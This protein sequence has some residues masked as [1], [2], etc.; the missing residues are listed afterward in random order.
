MRIQH[1]PSH[2]SKTN[3]TAATQHTVRVP[4]LALAVGEDK[5]TVSAALNG[6]G[7]V[8]PGTRKAVLRAA[9][10]LGFAGKPQTARSTTGGSNLIGL[11]SLD[12][13]LGVGT[14][15]IKTI[16]RLLTDNGYDVPVYSYGSTGAAANQAGLLRA[17]CRQQPQ[18]IVCANVGLHPD[19]LRELQTYEDKG[20]VVVCYDHPVEIA[21]DNV[22]FDREANTYQAARHLLEL[23][24]RDIALYVHGPQPPGPTRLGGFRRACA[25]FGVTVRPDWLF[26]GGLYET[27]GAQ[28]A[29]RFMELKQRPTA[30]CIVNDLA[31]V[32]FVNELRRMGLRVPA[33]VS[34]VGHD[35]LPM[36][37]YCALPLTTVSHPAGKIAR[38]VV[39]LL[40]S[41]LE[42]RYDGPPRRVVVQGELIVRASTAAPR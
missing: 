5:A 11:F 3:T 7:E 40:C 2:R 20:G 21:C 10:Q 27:G 6:T 18:A 35:D 28:M 4:D 14:S 8:A 17:L 39:D 24:H 38:H 1:K 13:D 19:A 37:R 23:G 22:V 41:H 15:K 29:A 25:E 33:D 30:L 9:R 31:A 26:H 16:Q 36:A 42:G 32:A 34:V 12:L